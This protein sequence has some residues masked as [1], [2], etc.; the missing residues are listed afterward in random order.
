MC[1]LSNVLV[2]STTS[3]NYT[4]TYNGVSYTFSVS[5]SASATGDAN[6]TD[7]AV[8]RANQLSNGENIIK[9]H[10]ILA[11]YTMGVQ[12][13]QYGNSADVCFEM[14]TNPVITYF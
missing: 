9:G 11:K 4:V 1:G 3:S 13:N 5:T 6:N 12:F 2:V 8:E 7:A 14:K 10:A